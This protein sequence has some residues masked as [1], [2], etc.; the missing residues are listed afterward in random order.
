LDVY[1]TLMAATKVTGP[2]NLEGK[3]LSPLIENPI[4]PWDGEAITQVLRP[5]DDRLKEPVMGCS[6]RTERYRYTEWGADGSKGIELYDHHADKGEFNN[7]AIT[8]DENVKA[9]INRLRPRLRAKA[10]GKTPTT[11]FNQKRL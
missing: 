7:L 1:P 11:P 6:I 2:D 10:S 3:D 4:R 9:V 8:A 5:A